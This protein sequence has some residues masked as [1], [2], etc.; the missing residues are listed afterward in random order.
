VTDRSIDESGVIY[1]RQ[2]FF[3]AYPFS[4]TAAIRGVSRHNAT[5]S[6]MQICT[7]CKNTMNVKLK[8]E[9]VKFLLFSYLHFFP[10]LQRQAGLPRG[11]Y[12]GAPGRVH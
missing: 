2:E 8:I 5:L 7:V 6:G 4:S 3:P 11:W 12:F 9:N 10:R 1:A